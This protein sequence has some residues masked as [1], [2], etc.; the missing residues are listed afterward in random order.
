MKILLTGA[1]GMLAADVIPVFEK[2]G[3]IVEKTD[4]TA[5]LS[6]TR[7]LDITNSN[8]V[9]CMITE[10]A[11]DYV[12]HFGAE[13]NVDYCQENPEHAYSVNTKGTKN[14]V[15]ACKKNSL[16]L[17]FIST[18]AV[19]GGEK[20]VPYTEKDIPNPATVYG[21]SKLRAEKIIRGRMDNYYIIRAGWMVGGWEI[22]KK[23][24][25]K[26]VQQI[27]EGKKELKVV[28]DKFGTP[29]FTKDFAD[30]L[31]KVVGVAP[32]GLYHMV[33]KGVCSRYEMALKIVE[34]MGVEGI[35]VIPVDSSEFPLPAPRAKSEMMQN[36]KL[37]R[38]ELNYMPR[39]EVSL[40]KYI[41]ENKNND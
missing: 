7:L 13:T 19:F 36:D 2:A 35:R 11:P 22:D 27:K 21:E 3:H 29:T 34:F 25:Y 15:E 41:E 4:I 33:N 18:G 28:A 12:F 9:F 20:D 32:Y 24:V 5:R 38:L 14:I 8:E 39:W 37:G 10:S 16:K 6:G 17:V 40:K 23:F 1:S 26:I 30:N 31:I